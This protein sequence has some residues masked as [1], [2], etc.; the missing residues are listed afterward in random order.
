LI[1]S[2]SGSSSEVGPLF[3]CMY[4][5]MY[6]WMNVSSMYTHTCVY[7][8]CICMYIWMNFSNVDIE[9]YAH[10]HAFLLLYVFTSVCYIFQP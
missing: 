4:V 10:I 7:T 8:F 3:L 5:C 6:V 1:K 9:L 2:G